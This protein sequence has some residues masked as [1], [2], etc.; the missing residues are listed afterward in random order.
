[1]TIV[2]LGRGLEVV[3]TAIDR[4]RGDWPIFGSEALCFKSASRPTARRT[5]A[6]TT[7][8]LGVSLVWI[9]VTLGLRTEEFVKQ[10]NDLWCRNLCRI[11]LI[12]V[13]V[14]YEVHLVGG[15]LCQGESLEEWYSLED[16]TAMERQSL[17]QHLECLCSLF[18]RN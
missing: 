2:F 13:L 1:M 15:S 17:D 9:R 12:L 14:Q 4:C 10:A 7:Y 8:H 16:P 18:H 3:F 11:R 6:L 5:N